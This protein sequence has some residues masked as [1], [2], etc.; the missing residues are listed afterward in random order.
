VYTPSQQDCIVKKNHWRSFPMCVY[1]AKFQRIKT[2][3]S[4]KP[5]S[6]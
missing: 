5:F 4:T 3:A 6:P 2:S 1:E